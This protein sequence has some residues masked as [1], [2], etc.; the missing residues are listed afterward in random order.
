MLKDYP[1]SAVKRFALAIRTPIY[2]RQ[3]LLNQSN[4]RGWVGRL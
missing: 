4:Q 1:Y 3:Y 2:R